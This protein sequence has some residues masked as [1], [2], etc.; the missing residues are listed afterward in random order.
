MTSGTVLGIDFGTTNSACAVLSGDD[1]E[2]LEN[3]EGDRLTPSVVYYT[4]ENEQFRPIV[5][6]QAANKARDNPER[7]IRSIKR[8]LGDDDT[9]VVDDKEYKVV[10]VAADII[11][12]IR[13]D[14]SEQLGVQRSELTDAVITTPAY[15]ESD[16][17]QAVIQAAELAGF[18][19]VRTI[20]EPASAAI[21]YGRFEPDLQ[22][23]VG[24]YDLGG[25][26]FDFA[27]VDVK[28]GR[29]TGEEYD[30]IA[31][32]GDPQLGGDDWD[33]RIID[34]VASEF[35]TRTGVNPLE[36]HY[37]DENSFSHL[38]RRERIRSKARSA[39]EQLS[40][41]AVTEVD[42]RIPFVMT[43]SDESKD[44]DLT[45][46]ESKFERM[47]T[48]LLQRTVDPVHTALS[49][50]GLSIHEVDEVILIGGSTRMPQ[51]KEKVKALFQNDPKDIIDPDEAVA[52]GAAVKGN[53][54]DIL[55][56]EV[57]PLSLGI[58]LKG[59]RFKRM[60]E[61]N[62]RLP[63]KGKETFTTSGEGDT[64]VRIPIYQG[65]RD[66]ASENRH[67]KTIIIEGMTPGSRHS[68]HVEVS[69]EVQQNGL[70]NVRAV[71]NT[72]NKEVSVEIEDEYRLSDEFIQD[73]LEE[74]QR[75]EE[76]DRRRLKVIEAQNQA[77]AAISNAE[78][79]LT[80]F[81]H[82]ISEEETEHIESHITNVRNTRRNE[83]ATLG[84]LKGATEDLNEWVMRVGDRIRKSDVSARTMPEPGPDVEPV[85]SD[86][87]ASTAPTSETG[88]VVVNNNGGE[89]EDQWDAVD[90]RSDTPD[91]LPIG[92][93]DGDDED[94]P[95]PDPD[96][97]VVGDDSDG[98]TDEQDKDNGESEQFEG[99]GDGDV[100]SEPDSVP[101]DIE[102]GDS[103]DDGDT[104]GD[105]LETGV[106]ELEQVK[107]GDEDTDDIGDEESD[108]MEEVMVDEND[109][110]DESAS[111]DDDY[112]ETEV[113]PGA[114]EETGTQGTLTGEPSDEDTFEEVEPDVIS[115]DGDSDDD[116]DDEG[117]P[118]QV[119]FESEKF[120]FQ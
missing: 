115:D 84:E 97:F 94:S 100:E 56:L 91:D 35:E 68:A 113:D 80:E 66:I 16:R 29:E 82:A 54:D 27:I 53:K 14:A 89:L 46:S 71:E 47:T 41:P 32:S 30:V 8:R 81:P 62:Q 48:D 38:V 90:E 31:S 107:S 18:E 86:P 9:I 1:P 63:A 2:I 106:D 6:S 22:K 52:V 110:A 67:L 104:L 51:V 11:R 64:A 95:I 19:S 20:K 102:V 73:K 118:E 42:I 65:E 50:A 74:A 109:S 72:R 37:S 120:S 116:E 92:D 36:P 112:D 85:E 61:R 40:N 76:L 3:G 21:A 34:W 28:I 10:E 111:V 15:W 45:L 96:A 26:T 93:N 23:T 4:Q 70:I 108:E 79:L 114:L 119:S 58:G 117:E 69:F 60:I 77:E 33:E 59:D 105:N 75:M 44:I 13:T 25:G 39:K 99:E 24:V 87:A 7:V 5:G 43:I 83:S 98:G 101:D 57:T 88:D 103:I 49:D 12:K 78:Q 17:K 55:L